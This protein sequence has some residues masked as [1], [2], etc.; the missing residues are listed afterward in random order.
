ML[1]LKWRSHATNMKC[2]MVLFSFNFYSLSNIIFSILDILRGEGGG[3]GGGLDFPNP[4]SERR[5]QSN[6]KH[7]STYHIYQE[8]GQD[9]VEL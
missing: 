6:T 9:N 4:I 5:N 1:R 7:F 8:T 2:F 3:N